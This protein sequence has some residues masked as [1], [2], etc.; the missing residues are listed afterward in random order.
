MSRQWQLNK[1]KLGNYYLACLR[2]VIINYFR[3]STVI[4]DQLSLKMAYL[5]MA[6]MTCKSLAL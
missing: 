4:K 6:D 3:P 2:S 1:T 5:D